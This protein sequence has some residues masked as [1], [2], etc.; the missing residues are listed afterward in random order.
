MS[1]QIAIDKTRDIEVARNEILKGDY[2]CAVVD[3]SLPG[4]K[5]GEFLSLTACAR[6]ATPIV[7]V[8]GDVENLD[9][10][11]A[12]YVSSTE[13]STPRLGSSV[14]KAIT[15]G[16]KFRRLHELERKLEVEGSQDSVT[17]LPSRVRF[18][19]RLEMEV[20]NV[21]GSD[22][23]LALLVLDLD[24][25]KA[26][27]YSLGYAIGDQLLQAVAERLNQTA[28][29]A[30]LVGRL[31]NDEFG[32]LLDL[33]PNFA[34]QVATKF[35]KALRVP[36]DCA[37]HQVEISATFGIAMQAPGDNATELLHKAMNALDGA[38]RRGVRFLVFDEE[39]E[40][41]R[42][43]QFGLGRDLPSAIE[44][45]QM[46]L[47]F[48]PKISMIDGNVTGVEALVRW[49]HPEHGL[50][51]P[52]NFIPLAERSGAIEPLTRWVLDAALKQASAWSALG[53]DL[54]ISVNV[55]ALTLHNRDFPNTVRTML[56]NWSFP[57]NRLTL[58]ITE[59]AFI[60]DVLRATDTLTRLHEL[61][62]RISIDDFG[63]GY[64]SLAYIRRLPID[65]LKVDKSF[66]MH[67]Q[68]EPDDSV[69]VRVLVQLGRSL[70]LNVVAEGVE[71]RETWYML[72]ALGCNCAQGYYMARPL[73]VPNFEKWL[74]SSAWGLAGRAVA[75]ASLAE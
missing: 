21:E 57:A 11:A 53:I 75:Q 28:P 49:Q 33:A 65:E 66:V 20:R 5:I 55:S 23:H 48:Q 72:A 36:F 42:R 45:G 13:I 43:L 60:S 25:F 32:I 19:D 9:L 44:S 22:N 16:R 34:S 10:G 2:D 7:V 8:G 41:E 68:S 40:G 52:D 26:F 6:P 62:V 74:Q 3:A 15:N 39:N 35:S 54:E 38:Q 56:A 1:Q 14:R 67:M 17:A 64:S 46:R 69:I 31:G 61:G 29:D 51:F 47:Y 73:D 70:G 58:E 50:V 30:K 59:S 18:H 24:G 71:D 4:L 63:T 12:E 27:N 37:G